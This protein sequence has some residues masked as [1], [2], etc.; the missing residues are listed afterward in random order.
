MC[1]NTIVTG[2]EKTGY[3]TQ[4]PLK[5]IRRIVRVHSNPGDKLLDFFA[6]SETFG[7]AAYLENRNFV[8]ID[9]S[10]EAVEV[11]KRRLTDAIKVANS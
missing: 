1:W 10:E 6:G 4:K 3:S 8:L 11:M 9:K 7:E 5:I 2:D